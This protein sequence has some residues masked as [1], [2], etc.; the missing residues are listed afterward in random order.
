MGR[1]VRGP[2]VELGGACSEKQGTKLVWAYD[3][4]QRWKLVAPRS[5][6]DELRIHAGRQV[7]RGQMPPA[8]AAKRQGEAEEN[9]RIPGRA[10]TVLRNE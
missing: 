9:V 7:G 1:A 3:V 10:F 8:L 2:G 6:H 4:P 5:H